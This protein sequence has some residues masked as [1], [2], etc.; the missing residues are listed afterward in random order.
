MNEDLDK[1]YDDAIK[2]TYTKIKR[3][4]PYTARKL[5][6]ILWAANK[7]YWKKRTEKIDDILEAA[8]LKQSITVTTPYITAGK[9]LSDNIRRIKAEYTASFHLSGAE[10]DRLLKNV[11]FDKTFMDNLKVMASMTADETQKELIL[12][13][14]SAPAYQFRIE[15]EEAIYKQA[16]ETMKNIAQSEIASDRAFLQS[17]IERENSFLADELAKGTPAEMVLKDIEARATGQPSPIGQTETGLFTETTQK[18][19][20]SSFSTANEQLLEDLGKR[21]YDGK[22][23]SERIWSNTDDLANDVKEL[24]LKAE[25]T[26]AGE[27]WISRELQKRYGVSAYQARRLV[28]TESSYTVNQLRLKQYQEQGYQEYMYVAMRDE[29]LCEVCGA[30]DGKVFKVKDAVVGVNYPYMHPF[31]RCTTVSAQS[32][33]MTEEEARESVNEM[34]DNALSALPP[35]PDGVNEIDWILQHT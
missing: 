11:K 12:A 10:A 25:L 24:L 14:I 23:F 18:G 4:M 30:L 22:S 9:W 29:S 26:G 2:A 1:I 13:T 19:I 21:K 16:Q 28:R 27:T 17:Q 32:Q 15:R 7:E 33:L 8:L 35:V 6:L 31:C 3:S 20:I 34:I 5:A